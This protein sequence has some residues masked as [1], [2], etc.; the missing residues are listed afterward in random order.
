MA[1]TAVKKTP[2][3]RQAERDQ[4]AMATKA[5]LAGSTGKVTSKGD[6]QPDPPGRSIFADS[7]E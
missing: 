3:Q 1:K 2:Q 5:G 7:D 4:Q 6:Y